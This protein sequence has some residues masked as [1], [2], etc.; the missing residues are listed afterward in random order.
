MPASVGST[1]GHGI[2]VNVLSLPLRSAKG[3][4]ITWETKTQCQAGHNK[5]LFPVP[6]DNT[7]ARTNHQCPK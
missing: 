7:K 3:G 1:A 4:S 6:T 5:N 2:H